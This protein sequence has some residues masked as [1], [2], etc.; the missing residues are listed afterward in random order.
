M[1]SDSLVDA[2]REGDAE[3]ADAP[4]AETSRWH[5]RWQWQQLEYLVSS[6][7]PATDDLPL[8][9][10]ELWQAE[11]LRDLVRPILLVGHV[12]RH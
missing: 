5:L 4:V 8:V 3:A 10:S 6:F 12:I 11:M 1:G 7:A 9:P 2:T